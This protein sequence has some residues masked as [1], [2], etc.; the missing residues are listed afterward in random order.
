[1]TI[2]QQ[3]SLC[4]LL[5]TKCESVTIVQHNF[6]QK[7]PGVELPHSIRRWHKQF[8][9]TGCPS[10]RKFPDH[11]CQKKMWSTS[12]SVSYIVH[13]KPLAVPVENLIFLQNLTCMSW[14][15]LF[16]KPYRI[17]LLQALHTSGKERR[18]KFCKFVLQNVPQNDD[19]QHS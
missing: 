19:F 5:F 15:R 2:A 14:K 18:L 11:P 6:L 3:K 10:K 9:D 16:S 17:Q 13:R 4:V 7:Y 1:M 12:D 8:Q